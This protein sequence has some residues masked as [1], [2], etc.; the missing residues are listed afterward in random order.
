ML[1]ILS[2]LA[3]VAVGATAVTAQ[4]LDGTATAAAI[5][6]AASPMDAFRVTTASPCDCWAGPCPAGAHRN[7]ASSVPEA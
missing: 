1:R 4:K 6:G 3:L 7:E 5:S 2:V